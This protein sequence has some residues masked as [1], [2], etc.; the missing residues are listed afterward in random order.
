MNSFNNVV[1][2]APSELP[3]SQDLYSIQFYYDDYLASGPLTN[4]NVMGYFATSI[5][6]TIPNNN[7]DLWWQ[8]E[9]FHRDRAEQAER[10]GEDV[11]RVEDDPELLAK[12]DPVEGL[13]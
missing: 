9:M 6:W 3:P 5:Y 11:E 12:H 10:D 8:A 13:K 1:P 2:P 4:Q 7:Q